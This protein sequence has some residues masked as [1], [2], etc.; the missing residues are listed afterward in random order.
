MGDPRIRQYETQV[1]DYFEGQPP[2]RFKGGKTIGTP[3]ETGVA[4]VFDDTW[5]SNKIVVK[6][7]GPADAEML[8]KESR[9]LNVSLPSGRNRLSAWL[10]WDPYT[11]TKMGNTY[12]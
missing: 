11:E 12:C 3:G 4:F 10:T 5:K 7:A 9:I 8:R 1:K 6:K 2:Y